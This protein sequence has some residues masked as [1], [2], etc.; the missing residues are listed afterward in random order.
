MIVKVWND[1]AHLLKETEKQANDNLYPGANPSGCWSRYCQ[2]CYTKLKSAKPEILQKITWALKIK[3]QAVSLEKFVKA[4]YCGQCLC[5]QW[6]RANCVWKD[7]PKHSAS[8]GLLFHLLFPIFHSARVIAGADFFLFCSICLFFS[9]IFY[10]YLLSPFKKKKKLTV[11][12]HA[13][14]PRRLDSLDHGKA[15]HGP[16]NQQTHGHLPIQ[17]SALRDAVRDVQGLAVP[18]VGGCWAFLTLWHHIYGQKA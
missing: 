16:G 14:L 13:Y 3:F 6:K 1:N 10:W 5:N 15:N 12:N 9:L 17:P 8:T 4:H 11:L 7:F 2:L 18:V